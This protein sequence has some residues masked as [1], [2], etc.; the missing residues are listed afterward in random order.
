[1]KKRT[2]IILA[3]ILVLALFLRI[4]RLAEIPPSLSWDEAS[5]GYDA[6]SVTL[7]GQDQWGRSLPFIFKSF[8]E[9]K[10]PFHIYA[11]ALS[12]KLLGLSDFAVRLPSVFMGVVNIL[13]LFFL[14]KKITR[15]EMAAIL[16]SVFLAISPWSIQFSRVNWETNFALFFFFLGLLFFVYRDQKPWFLI[17]AF[18]FFGLDLYTYNAPKVFIPLFVAGLLMINIKDFLK[19]KFIFSSAL[20]I[21]GLF[22][23]L[24]LVNP[25]LSGRMR[26]QQVSFDESS[27]QGAKIYAMTKNRNLGKFELIG[28]KY[29]SHFSPQF[30]FLSGD[31]NPRHSTQLVGQLYWFDLILIPV[32]LIMLLKDRNKLHILILL[33]FFLSPVPA[34]IAKEAPHA[35]RAMFAIGGW[36]IVSAL[37]LAY[38]FNYCKNNRQKIILLAFTGTLLAALFVHYIFSYFATYSNKYAHEWQYGYKRLVLDYQLEFKKYD[39]VI[40]SDHYAQPYIFVLYYLR[41]SPSKFREEAEYNSTDKWGMSTVA[42]F[43]NFEFK[44]IIWDELPKG[45][46]LVFA[47]PLERSD[48]IS[49][50]ATVKNLDGGTA[51]YVYEYQK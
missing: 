15:S 37:G 45:R 40:L 39:K 35:S 29:I 3:V 6:W 23:I 14:V 46:L 8:G 27:I 18:L 47:S 17:T 12:I 43:G 9:F 34:S 49:E 24:T 11:T 7:D 44:K 22:L 31:K 19:Q 10:Y 48:N 41:Y 25:E 1:M 51:F 32:G 36:Q 20:F 16:S 42:S 21:F 2:A 5:I 13:L 4:Y 50:K 38:I 26:F 30:L 28:K 33:W